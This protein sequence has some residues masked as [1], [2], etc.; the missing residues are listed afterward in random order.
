MA[1]KS[2]DLLVLLNGE[3][4]GTVRQ[5][6][7]GKLVLMYDRS[8]RERKDSYPLSLSM[9]LALSE[10]PDTV[11]R[12]FLE[13]L[14]PDNQK[15]LT[16]WGTQFHVSSRNPF[17]LLTHMGE[18]CAGAVQLVVPDRLSVAL[19][20]V[21]EPITWL[22]ESDIAERL[23][24]AVEGHGT[25]RLASDH[26]HFSL[27]GAQP[28]TALFFDG[29]RWG[30]PTGSVPTTHIVKPPAQTDLDG[31]DINE[32]FCLRL[33]RE[34]GLA[35]AESSI[36]EFDGKNAI[37]VE[38]YDRV[39]TDGATVVRLHQEDAC[40]SLGISPL[41]KYENEGGPGAP[42]IVDLL[43]RHSS[44]PSVDVGAF[45][46]ALALNW[47]IAGTD[48]HAKNYSVLLS[49]GSTRLAPLYDLLSALPYPVPLPY[50]SLKLA[51]RVDG[52][53]HVWKISGRHWKGLA[54]RCDLDPV[55][56]VQR[57][58]DLAEMVPEAVRTT[59][60][61]VRAEGVDHEIIDRLEETI[62]EHSTN[63]LGLLA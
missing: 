49:R 41:R 32:H 38:R 3:N 8:W 26:G 55:P 61:A 31:F 25:G 33:S 23:R 42:E 14:L 62:T 60:A 12:P 9:P 63:C 16:R 6:R 51:M 56:L 39:W 57:V 13:G 58:A 10:H 37:V 34:L 36:R 22:T 29:H 59:A 27:A 35:A 21:G 50:R 43:F 17:A 7:G 24:D 48:G 11:V 28:K 30:I 44:D 40:Q 1:P 19:G 2:T 18:D 45:L 20:S 4:V 47:V 53:Y 54:A 15:V 5:K 46:D 52:E